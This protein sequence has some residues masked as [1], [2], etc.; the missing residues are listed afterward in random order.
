MLKQKLV[1]LFFLKDLDSFDREFCG[2]GDQ[3]DIHV[4]PEEFDRNSSSCAILALR[5]DRSVDA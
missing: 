5:K 2:F 1:L 4:E 3:V